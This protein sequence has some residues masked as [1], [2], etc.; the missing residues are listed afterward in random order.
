[1]EELISI[2]KLENIHRSICGCEQEPSGYTN[3]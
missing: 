2:M 1:M 3:N